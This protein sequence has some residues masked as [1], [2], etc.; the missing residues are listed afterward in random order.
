MLYK[1]CL[2]NP[3]YKHLYLNELNDV[4]DCDTFFP[5]IDMKDYKLIEKNILSSN[6]TANHYIKNKKGLK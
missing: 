2:E 5:K 3:D 1:A 6:V 4:H